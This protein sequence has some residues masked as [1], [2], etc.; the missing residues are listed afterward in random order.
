MTLDEIRELTPNE[1]SSRKKEL[2]QEIFHLRLQQ[3]AGQLEKPHL[4][5]NLRREIARLETVLTVKTKA[6]KAPATR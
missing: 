5:R 1:I 2:R 4:L 6:T 3:Q